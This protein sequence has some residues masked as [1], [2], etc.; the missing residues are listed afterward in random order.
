MASV[1]A[2]SKAVAMLA[3]ARV[4]RTENFMMDGKVAV[5]EGCWGAADELRMKLVL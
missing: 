5:G 2:C 1:K 4:E 3:R